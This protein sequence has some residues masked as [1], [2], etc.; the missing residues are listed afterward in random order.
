MN[1]SIIM[2]AIIF[3]GCSTGFLSY[4]AYHAGM[5][6]QAAE[7]AKI[8]KTVEDHYQAALAAASQAISRIEVR[9]VI[10]NRKLET[11][12]RDNPVFRDCHSG[13]D[14][15]QLYNSGI[16]GSTQSTHSSELPASATAPR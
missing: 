14:S 11:V 16:D 1:L 3:Y 15:L 4:K 6:H 12:I 9:N 5:E 13:P 2:G 7:S 8:T 10:V